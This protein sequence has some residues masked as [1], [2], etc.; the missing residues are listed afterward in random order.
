GAG[1]EILEISRAG[2]RAGR[3]ERSRQSATEQSPEDDRLHERTDHAAALAE[4]TDDLALPQREDGQSAHAASDGT[5]W[6]WCPVR[7][8]NTPWSVGRPTRIAWTS[9]G[10]A[11]TRSRTSSWPRGCSRRSVPSM[12]TAS[13][14]KR[15]RPLLCNPPTS[16]AWITT[17]S[18][19]TAA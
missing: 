1:K 4:E 8:T 6:S 2:G 10:K 17:T 12:R 11:S 13:P 19:P 5:A 7:W 9:A 15:S 3:P 16:A 14:P 18:P